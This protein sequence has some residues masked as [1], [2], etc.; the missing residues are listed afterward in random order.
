MRGVQVRTLPHN[1]ISLYQGRRL[2]AAFNVAPRRGEFCVWIDIS[3]AAWTGDENTTDSSLAPNFRARYRRCRVPYHL[4][5]RIQRL[6]RRVHQKVQ[7]Y[8]TPH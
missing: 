5:R 8:P 7:R 3:G 1:A 6:D 2:I 4:R